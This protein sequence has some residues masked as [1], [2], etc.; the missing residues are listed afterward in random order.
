MQVHKLSY[1]ML[2][3]LGIGAATCAMAQVGGPAASAG[4]AVSGPIGIISTAAGNGIEGNSGNGGPATKAELTNPTSV[5]VDTAGNIYIAEMNFDVV[6]KV[7][8]KTGVITVYAGNGVGGYS[9][10]GGPATSAELNRPESVAVDGNGNLYIA[11]TR[12]HVIRMVAAK[13]GT[14]TTVA[15]L[16]Y[17]A[18]IHPNQPANQSGLC[19][20]AGV[21]VDGAG[22]LYIA[23][24]GHRRIEEVTKQ[25]GTIGILAGNGQCC[26]Y[27]GDG[28][29]ALNAGLYSPQAVAVDAYGSL[30]I[31]DTYHCAIRRVTNGTINSLVGIPGNNPFSSCGFSG[32]GGPASQAHL[33]YPFGVAV[34][35]EGDVFIADG[36]NAEVRVVHG[37]GI[38]AVAGMHG[39]APIAEIPL[40]GYSGD[41]GP[42][43]DALLEEPYGVTVDGSGNLWIADMGAVVRKVAGIAL[44]AASMPLATP[45]ISPGS[46]PIAGQTTVSITDSDTTTI[47]YTTDG[48]VPTTASQKYKGSFPVSGSTVVTAFATLTGHP[49]SMAATAYYLYAPAPQIAPGTS[50]VKA[51]VTVSIAD[52]NASAAIYY[53]VDGTDPTAGG[54]TA[55]LY[56]GS[57]A[58][59]GTATVRAAALATIS[60]PGGT[61]QSQWSAISTATYT[62]ETAA[63]SGPSG[64]LSTVAGNGKSGYNGD[65][66]LAKNAQ[67]TLVMGVAGDLQGNLYLTD[68]HASVVRKVTA[69]TGKISVVAG[70]AGRSGYSGDNGPATKALLNEPVGIAVDGAGNLFIADSGNLVIRKVTAATGTITTVAGSGAHIPQ[71]GCIAIANGAPALTQPFCYPYSVAVDGAGNLFINDQGWSTIFKVTA[72]DGA[73]GAVAGNGQF[74]N[75]YYDVGDG[76]LALDAPLGQPYG[77]AVD[78]AGNLYIADTND[79]TIRRVDA[80]TGIITRVTG[81]PQGGCNWTGDGGAAL[82]A[83][84]CYPYSVAVDGGGNLYIGDDANAVVRMIDPQKNIYTI[85]GN[86]NYYGYAGDGGPAAYGSLEDPEAMAVDGLGNLYIA[87]SADYAIRKVTWAA[88]EPTL[89]PVISPGSGTLTALPTVTIT[90]PGA[91]ATVYY[92]T[93]GTV[94]STKSTKYKGSFKLTGSALVTAFATNPSGPNSPASEAAYLYLPAPKITPGTGTITGATQV[95]ISD[96]NAAAKIYYT[97][98]GSNPTQGG[99]SVQAYTGPFTVSATTTVNAAA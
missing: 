44:P 96:D 36:Y 75:N 62:L 68:Y 88:A 74:N 59:N 71:S 46:G 16:G 27:S 82:G 89:E 34:D 54:G 57:F 15:G 93:N 61:V 67:I 6:R 58:V 11:D 21:A 4:A 7:T 86:I 2:I 12:N 97:L 33:Y 69:S 94:P 13:T 85:F 73:I 83:T 64:I 48:T 56:K 65:G 40:Q 80:Q 35:G 42:S 90:A 49:N 19:S 70:I 18:P 24:T 5:A 45:Q 77:I 79:S 22:N 50:I 78:A 28:G 66:G 9:G 26:A 17:C 55:T 60:G 84:L 98:D 32:D 76:G 99:P 30:Y 47:Y 95:T 72:S 38:Y 91:G 92:T 10:D 14:I 23:D 3:A 1:F 51:G 25:T 87:D 63:Q 8:A 53:T 39:G 37:G 52:G 41:G 81:D 29:P 20:P 31:A 43:T